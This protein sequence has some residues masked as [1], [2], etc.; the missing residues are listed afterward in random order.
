MRVFISRDRDLAGPLADFLENRGAQVKCQSLISTEVI[1]FEVPDTEF[2]WI[3]FSSQNAVRY[4][5]SSG[6]RSL[7][8]LAAIGPVT[9]AE[10]AKFGEVAFTGEGNDISR[11]AH[12]FA[13]VARGARV[14]F[15]ISTKSLKNVQKGLNPEQ[16]IN[17]A[18]YQTLPKPSVV[19]PADA[20]L[21]SSPSN[22]HSFAQNNDFNP[23]ALYLSGPTTS[24]VL[25]EYGIGNPIT[26]NDWQQ[27]TVLDAIFSS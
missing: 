11:V 18:C 7:A 10:L 26:L 14:L 19:E 16:V 13:E 5:Y 6:H 25:R 27:S 21:F 9:A 1:P 2:D 15:P 3:F 23:E 17:L 22:V 12:K 8:K 4:F 24:A 20:Y